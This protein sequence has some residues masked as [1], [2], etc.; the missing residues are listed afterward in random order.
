MLPWREPTLF[1]VS[2][3]S[4]HPRQGRQA[5]SALGGER[6]L[7][8]VAL[9]SRQAAADMRVRRGPEQPPV[10]RSAG[11]KEVWLLVNSLAI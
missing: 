3:P 1:G 5:L 8:A 6:R 2:G 9:V 10:F 7:R 4:P 11:T